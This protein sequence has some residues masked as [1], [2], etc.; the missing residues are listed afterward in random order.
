MK[1][2]IPYFRGMVP[3]QSS[4]LLPDG[5]AADCTNVNLK[6]G[7]L[8]AWNEPSSITT[9]TPAGIKTIYKMQIAD[10]FLRWADDVNV[11]RGPVAGDTTERLYFT[12]ARDNPSSGD[13]T[14]RPKVT[15]YSKVTGATLRTGVTSGNYPHDWLI[16]GVPAPDSFDETPVASAG[17]PSGDSSFT[18][19][20]Y[21]WVNELGDEGKP[22]LASN[23]IE[24]TPGDTVTIT[25]IDDPVGTDITDY[26]LNSSGEKRLYRAATGPDGATSY[27]F[28][29]SVPYGTTSTTDELEDAELGEVLESEDYDLPPEDGH[30]IIAL[31]NGITVMASKN[32]IFLSAQNRP[33]AYPAD[34]ALTCDFDIVGLGAIDTTVVILTRANPYIALG[35]S[36][37]QFS[38]AKI[39]LPYGCVAKRSIAHLKG[40]G[41]IYAS[42]NGLAAINGSGVNLI[43]D[44]YFTR[45]QWQALT[46][47]S[48]YGFTHDDRYFFFFDSI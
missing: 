11:A 27:F 4:R 2:T 10:I 48:I 36:P 21:T 39:E 22:S 47:E 30:S 12:G 19:Y 34:F 26:G 15:N 44:K 17:A 28:V 38:M 40:F 33:H 45:E 3:R 20:V 14:S 18:T 13:M 37:D 1:I 25:G 31:P 9:L 32:Q 6:S 29:K 7:D 41:I 35:S 46:P 16:L 42:P 8:A 23:L 5:F 24:F 43:S